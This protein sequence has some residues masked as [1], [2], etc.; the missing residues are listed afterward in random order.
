[1]YDAAEVK[2]Y[3]VR[4]ELKKLQEVDQVR[5]ASCVCRQTKVSAANRSFFLRQPSQCRFYEDFHTNSNSLAL[6][7]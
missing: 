2:Q 7:F 4:Q 6:P 3:I 5:D 1:M